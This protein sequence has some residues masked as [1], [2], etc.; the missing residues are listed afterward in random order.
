MTRSSNFE[1]FGQRGKK[2]EISGNNFPLSLRYTGEGDETEKNN[3][4]NKPTK[5]L[6]A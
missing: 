5:A 3:V 6:I 2:A 1:L 4:T